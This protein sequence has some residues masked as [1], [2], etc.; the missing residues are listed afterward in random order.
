MKK[1]TPFIKNKKALLGISS[2]V[3]AVSIF[4]GSAANLIG[5]RRDSDDVKDDYEITNIEDSD[6]IKDDLNFGTIPYK[7]KTYLTLQEEDLLTLIEQ[8]LAEVDE[9]YVSNENKTV[10]N[11]KDE[12]YSQFTPYDILGLLFTESTFRLLEVKD[13][14]AGIYNV[15][16]Y[17]RFYGI[18]EKGV[19]YYGPGMMNKDAIKYIIQQDRQ[20]V[21]NFNN[22]D[23]IQIDGKSVQISF[24]NINPYDY[25]IKSG[26]V[27]EQEVKQALK[28]SILLNIKCIYIT[29]NR[30]VKD[31]VKSGTHDYELKILNS[32][33]QFNN[34]TI[35]EKQKVYAFIAY[36]NGPT[37]TRSNMLNGTLFDKYTEGENKGEYIVNFAYG[38]KV[39][40]KSSEY[41][42]LCAVKSLLD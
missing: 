36:N 16:N 4:I 30:F 11:S 17:A 38:S 5:S 1:H 18:D 19:I 9:E 7:G 35:E 28:E 23:Y 15:D 21:N 24:E 22:P 41:E 26:A 14:K 42:N 2:A 37:K 29:L 27:S 10:F 39:L 13:K 33:K 6:N 25:V 40:K 3:L 8:A 34:L 32:Y 20:N 12:E 31:N